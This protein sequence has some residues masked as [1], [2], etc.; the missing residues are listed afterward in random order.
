MPE[1]TEL[2]AKCLTLKK[3]LENSEKGAGWIPSNTKESFKVIFRRE[4]PE[5]KITR[6]SKNNPENG[7]FP[8]LCSAFSEV[9]SNNPKT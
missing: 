8:S 6:K 2:G 5:A 4:P 9:I 3:Q 7:Q 1:T